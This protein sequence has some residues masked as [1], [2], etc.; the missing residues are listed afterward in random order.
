MSS[1]FADQRAKLFFDSESDD[2]GLVVLAPVTPG[3]STLIGV[4]LKRVGNT[5]FSVKWE[6]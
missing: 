3:R 2:L 4:Q 6:L 1:S 5:Y